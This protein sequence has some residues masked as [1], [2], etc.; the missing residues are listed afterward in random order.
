MKLLIAALLFLSMNSFAQTENKTIHDFKIKILNSDEILDF[1]EFKGKKILIVNVAS[2]CGYTPQYEQLEALYK[3]YSNQLVV[4]G[5]PC[6]QFMSQELDTEAAIAEFC[7]AKFEVSFP[8]T[9]IVN[10]KGKEQH[11]IY[12]WLTQKA[13][14]GK[15]DYEISWNFNKFLLDENG[16]ILEYFPSKVTPMD[17]QITKYFK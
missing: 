7:S 6:D 9:T 3:Q 17:E 10:V 2:K 13:M 1:S 4:V 12:Q 5:F 14:N 15:G 11:P 16:Q 8:M